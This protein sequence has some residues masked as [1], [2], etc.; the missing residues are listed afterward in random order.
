[1]ARYKVEI[2]QIWECVSYVDAK[3]RAEADK[4]AETR[5][6]GM[7]PANSIMDFKSQ[8][9]EVMKVTV[10]AGDKIRIIRMEGEPRYTAKVGIVDH[11]DDLGQIHGTWGGCALI[12]GKD[13]FVVI[14]GKDDNLGNYSDHSL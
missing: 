6:R 9:V 11:I 4:L 3:S 10:E 5:A 13:Q 2:T 7:T 1:M 8:S 14:G 12:P